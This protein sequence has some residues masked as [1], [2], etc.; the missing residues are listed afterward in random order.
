MKAREFGAP[1]AR[2]GDER[3]HLWSSLRMRWAPLIERFAARK[4]KAPSSGWSAIVSSVTNSYWVS[5][6][7]RIVDIICAI[8]GKGDRVAVRGRFTRGKC[9]VVA[10]VSV[11][12]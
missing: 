8:G 10:V 2:I 9:L 6:P 5:T 12:R 7:L 1:A 4:V 11:R 3:E